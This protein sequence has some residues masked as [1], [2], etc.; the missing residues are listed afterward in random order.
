MLASAAAVRIRL[1]CKA[2]RVARKS[3]APQASAS[4]Q[5][6]AGSQGNK[7]SCV[8]ALQAFHL[9]CQSKVSPN[10]LFN[11]SK[12]DS[13][14]SLCLDMDLSTRSIHL[15]CMNECLHPWLDPFMHRQFSTDLQDK[16]Q[17]LLPLL[18]LQRRNSIPY[19]LICTSV[20]RAAL[21]LHNRWSAQHKMQPV[22]RHSHLRNDLVPNQ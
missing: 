19:M 13:L 18:L 1:H 6:D 3:T 10:I 12:V 4:V 7:R 22:M 8:Q 20:L 16:H 5:Q 17:L 21:L 2:Q 15:A 14:P 9:A 11:P